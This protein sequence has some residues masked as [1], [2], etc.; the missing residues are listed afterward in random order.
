MSVPMQQSGLP[1]RLQVLQQ[2][3]ATLH[4]ALRRVL[5]LRFWQHRSTAEIAQALHCTEASVK[6]LQHQAL[7]ELQHVT[8]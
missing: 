1:P 3:L 4:P 8:T 2:A 7:L 5:A 6:V